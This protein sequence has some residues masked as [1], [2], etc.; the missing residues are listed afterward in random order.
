MFKFS[1]SKNKNSC[2]FP[3]GAMDKGN[4]FDF[5]VCNSHWPLVFW[6]SGYQTLT[7]YQGKCRRDKTTFILTLQCCFLFLPSRMSWDSQSRNT[8]TITYF[9]CVF[10][11]SLIFISH[12]TLLFQCNEDL[13]I[14]KQEKAQK[15]RFWWWSSEGWPKVSEN[16]DIH[17]QSECLLQVTTLYVK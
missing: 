10:S 13:L 1:I 16:K 4:K 12:Y 8:L 14:Q 15:I 3:E 6:V 11:A 2:Y 7:A 9:W 5:S 17:G